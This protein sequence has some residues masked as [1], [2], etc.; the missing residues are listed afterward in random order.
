MF[1]GKDEKTNSFFQHLGKAEKDKRDYTGFSRSQG[2][3]SRFDPSSD[4]VDGKLKEAAL[5]YNVDDDEGV[6]DGYSFRPDVNTW[7]VNPFPRV[8]F[9]YNSFMRCLNDL[10][11]MLLGLHLY[12][13]VRV[14]YHLEVRTCK[15]NE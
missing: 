6:K 15:L 1:G 3:G 2:N 14:F 8:C 10:I 9:S 5:I 11:H 12:C 4:G 7:G 13:K